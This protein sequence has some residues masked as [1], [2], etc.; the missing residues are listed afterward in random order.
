MSVGWQ[1]PTTLF[2]GSW[3]V[4]DKILKGQLLSPKLHYTN[5][6]AHMLATP[7][8][9]KTIIGFLY[10]CLGCCVPENKGGKSPVLIIGVRAGGWTRAKPLFWGQ[11]L[12]FRAEANS[13]KWKKN[14]YFLT[15]KNEFILSSEMQ[16][17]KSGIF[18]NNY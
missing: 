14:L 15:E 17:P 4:E 10:D 18:T 13:Q 3:E 16:C 8:V 5:I 9:V 7:P 6:V 12:N 2:R 11:K 1:N